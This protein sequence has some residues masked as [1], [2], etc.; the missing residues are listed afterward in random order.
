EKTAPG[1]QIEMYIQPGYAWDGF[2]RPIVILSPYKIPAEK[3]KALLDDGSLNGQLVPVW[4]RYSSME[5]QGLRQGFEVCDTA[6][7]N[8]RIQESFQIEVGERPS[9]ADQHD[10]ISLAGRSVDAR[11]ALQRFD[12]ADPL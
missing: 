8:S 10:P 2:G 11:Q 1:G 6:D 4:V 9:H 7:Q 5:T 12:P 3:F